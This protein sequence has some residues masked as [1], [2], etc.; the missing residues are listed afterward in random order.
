MSSLVEGARPVSFSR[1]RGF[2]RVAPEH[3]RTPRPVRH[4]STSDLEG[5]RDIPST[6]GREAR[7]TGLDYTRV[8]WRGE[9]ERTVASATVR[10]AS[11]EVTG[12][13]N[14]RLQLVP[15]YDAKVLVS[16]PRP[17]DLWTKMMAL[18]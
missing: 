6:T 3:T 7:R 9:D 14:L 2:G 13:E 11:S 18:Y 16:L 1:A 8:S 17:S 15:S 5:E 4:A 12:S 10:R